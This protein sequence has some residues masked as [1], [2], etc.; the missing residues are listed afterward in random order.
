MS[1]ALLDVQKLDT[2][3]DCG[4]E[5]CRR[6]KGWLV[7]LV[8]KVARAKRTT[9]SERLVPS[10]ADG[11]GHEGPDREE[12]ESR[13]RRG[14]QPGRPGH[15]RRRYEHLP[16]GEEVTLEPPPAELVCAKCGVPCELVTEGSSA[17]LELEIVV[18]RRHTRR[19]AYRPRCQCGRQT[20]IQASPRP[21]LIP[22][23]LLTVGTVA[24]LVL[25]KFELGLPV[26]R[27]S[28]MLAL[29]GTEL[30]PGTVAGVFKRV[31]PLLEALAARIRVHTA[32]SP[33]LHSDE[34][35]WRLLGLAREA[36]CRSCGW[37]WV[38]V[39]HDSVSFRMARTRATAELAKHLGLDPE[40]PQ[41]PADRLLVL[42]CDRY[43]ANLSL[44]RQCPEIVGALCWAH[45]RRDFWELREHRSLKA[46]ARAW[47]ERI[48]RLYEAHTAWN[49]APGPDG[50]TCE[51]R[52]HGLVL[53][54]LAE[55]EQTL[56][57]ELEAATLPAP[58][59]K[60]L[61]S[62]DKHWLGLQPATEVRTIPLDNNP[63]ERALR[64]PVIV[65]RNCLGSASEW[66]AEMAAAAWTVLGTAKMA[67]WN[68]ARHLTDYLDACRLAGDVPADL[69]RF[70]P[71]AASA[72]D[73]RRWSQSEPDSS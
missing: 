41:M 5:T 16:I 4:C 27:I 62:L 39:G 56:E 73:H 29:T 46:W 66:S 71:W 57:R 11:D 63:A 3:C 18:R 35:G 72:T 44:L 13:R 48:G 65:E 1:E 45:V 17:E 69:D 54:A 47:L 28:G 42:S 12:S 31:T 58:A 8:V 6:Q 61:V 15:G 30:A 49:Q 23:G 32:D 51:Q 24:W 33:H 67:G 34:T 68:P 19:P 43:S 36:T 2:H 25:L 55:I 20:L 60:A 7:E 50:S 10:G 26:Q 52:L 70:L 22:K 9:V 40:H 37:L 38:L 59:L 14:Q 53:A 64:N 21:K